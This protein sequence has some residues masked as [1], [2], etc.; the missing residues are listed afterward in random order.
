[1]EFLLAPDG[2]FYFMEMNTRIQV[3]HPV[4]ELVTSVDLIKEQIRIAAGEKLAIPQPVEFQG[5]AIEC[6]IN[7]EDPEQGFRPSPGT[8]TAFHAPGGPGVRVDTHIYGG[9]VVPPFYDSL[10]AKLV[11]WGRTRD[12]ARIRAYHALEEFILEGVHTT[13]PFLRKVLAHPDFVS[14]NIDTGFVERFLTRS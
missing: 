10:L 1:M 5:H 3:E 9:Y 4:T 12:E 7:A 14:G 11:V 6:R 13:V 2:E 8:V